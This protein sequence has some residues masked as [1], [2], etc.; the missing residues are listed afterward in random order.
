[1]RRGGL[2]QDNAGSMAGE[3]DAPAPQPP[4]EM[5]STLFNQ[6]IQQVGTA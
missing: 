4:K 1:M 6:M 3:Q 5:N 2:N